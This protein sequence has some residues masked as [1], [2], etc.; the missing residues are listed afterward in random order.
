MGKST[1]GFGL[2]TRWMRVMMAIM[3]VDVVMMAFMKVDVEASK[4]QAA[5]TMDFL[6]EFPSRSLL[7]VSFVVLL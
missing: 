3:K 2:T 7:K 4:I 1:L 5:V 6:Y